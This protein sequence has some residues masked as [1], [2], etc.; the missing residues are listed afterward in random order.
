MLRRRRCAGGEDESDLSEGFE[1]DDDEEPPTADGPA[2]P[3]I[4]VA[5]EAQTDAPRDRAWESGS[6]E[7]GGT[8]FD[9]E[10]DSDMNSQESRSD[11]EDMED[12]ASPEQHREDEGEVVPRPSRNEGATPPVT[13]GPLL[14]A[15]PSS[16]SSNL[17]AMSSQLFQSKPRFR[18]AP[19]FSNVLLRPSNTPTPDTQPVPTPESTPTPTDTL[20]NTSTEIVNGTND[21]GTSR[22]CLFV[23]V[24]FAFLIICVVFVLR[25]RV[26]RQ[27]AQHSVVSQ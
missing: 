10:T 7:E 24:C 6:E 1:S 25:R 8:A 11:L 26:G 27:R 4:P 18:L 5:K 16:I 12:A 19:T 20:S 21:D 13:N 23:L 3:A 15:D 17:Q 22:V 14:S 9:V 2:V